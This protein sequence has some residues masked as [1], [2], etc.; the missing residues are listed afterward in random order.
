MVGVVCLKSFLDGSYNKEYHE[1]HNWSAQSIPMPN[2]PMEHTGRYVS[3]GNNSQCFDRTQIS[4]NHLIEG[5]QNFFEYS[6][7]TPLKII[8]F[9]IM[10]GFLISMKI[11]NWIN[12]GNRL[13]GRWMFWL[14]GCRTFKT[15]FLSF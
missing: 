1:F 5:L 3:N 14:C 7:R 6:K 12:F 8:F 9:K 10:W 4:L 11:L 13:M 15:N 2:A